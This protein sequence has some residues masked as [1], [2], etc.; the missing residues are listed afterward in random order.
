[1]VELARQVRRVRVSNSL[2]NKKCLVIL[3]LFGLV[4]NNGVL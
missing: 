3:V 2:L 4:R 1:M